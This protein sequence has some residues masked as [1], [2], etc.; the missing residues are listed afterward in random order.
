MMSTTVGDADADVDADADSDAAV[1]GCV[2][3]GSMLSMSRRHPCH[4][5]IGR[6]HRAQTR[7][8]WPTLAAPVPHVPQTP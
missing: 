7:V 2:Q 1:G 3:A 8:A 4:Q 6:L 5:P